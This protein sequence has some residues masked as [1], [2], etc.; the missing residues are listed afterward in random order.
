M[1]R[2]LTPA[3]RRQR[4]REKERRQAASRARTAERRAAERRVR[5]R[6]K[7]ETARKSKSLD[8]AYSS[9]MEA[10]MNLHLQEKHLR[11]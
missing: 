10:I 9:A 7:A 2:R 5:E 1:G 8:I 3:E 11:K 6:E 4:E